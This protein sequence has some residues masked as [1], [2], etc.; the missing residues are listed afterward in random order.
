MDDNLHSDIVRVI[1]PHCDHHTPLGIV[2]LGLPTITLCENC[3]S[4]FT[5]RAE[6]IPGEVRRAKTDS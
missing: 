2:R 5:L 3:C 4:P 6:D 1:C